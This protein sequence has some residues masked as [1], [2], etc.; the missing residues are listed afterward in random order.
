MT[1]NVSR[2]TRIVWSIAFSL[3]ILSY[4]YHILTLPQ[5]LQQFYYVYI[6]LVAF[7]IGLIFQWVSLRNGKTNIILLIVAHIEMFCGLILLLFTAITLKLVVCI[8]VYDSISYF[9]V[10]SFALAIS[11]IIIPFLKSIRRDPN[12]TYVKQAGLLS[13][14]AAFLLFVGAVILFTVNIIVAKTVP[15][16]P[17]SQCISG[18]SSIQ[19]Y[20]KVIGTGALLVSS[21]DIVYSVTALIVY[22]Y[23]TWFK[24]DN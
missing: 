23:I 19:D 5:N 9:T 11:A 3:I 4:T 20:A 14:F 1:F 22:F 12:M 6:S 18:A 8:P 10:G 21:L 16:L 17:S 13:L 2:K 15:T 7:T 24:S